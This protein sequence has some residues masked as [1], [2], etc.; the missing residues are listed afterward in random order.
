MY[1]LKKKQNKTNTKNHQNQK[2][3]THGG[4]QLIVHMHPKEKKNPQEI[5]T[6]EEN[7]DNC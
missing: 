5:W 3:K 2:T 1:L 7:C 6:E 4:L